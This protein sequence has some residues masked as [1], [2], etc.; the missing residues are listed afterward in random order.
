M[1]EAK[2]LA[3]IKQAKIYGTKNKNRAMNCL[4]RKKTLEK[5]LE[6]T[7]NQLTN[8]QSQLVALESAELN[9]EILLNMKYAGEALEKANNGMSL[10]DV[11]NMM[12]DIQDAK[13]VADE[14]NEAIARPLANSYEYDDD[15]LL[16]ELEQLEQEELDSKMLD[17]PSASNGPS[18]ESSFS[19]YDTQTQ[20][21]QLENWSSNPD[22][23][24]DVPVSPT[25]TV[26]TQ[27][28]IQEMVDWMGQ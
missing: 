4:K 12:D 3:E 18:L 1:I 21:R 27:A 20:L 6:T 14:I 10:D 19:P 17:V 2:I 5:Q 25:E 13:D 22:A 11:D 23:S 24:I 15:D 7:Y 26:R 28:Q 9:G 16:A 8:I